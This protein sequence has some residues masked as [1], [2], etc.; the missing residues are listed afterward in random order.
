VAE[1]RKTGHF[2]V[3]SRQHGSATR[4]GRL[5]AAECPSNEEIKRLIE[6]FKNTL[7]IWDP[8]LLDKPTVA[9]GLG[10]RTQ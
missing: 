5:R 9:P 7:T 4:I 3:F 10:I 8:A 2:R 1:E 6:R